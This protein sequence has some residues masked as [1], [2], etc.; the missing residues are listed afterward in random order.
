MPTRL[1]A[2]KLALLPQGAQT[3]GGITVGELVEYG[4]FPHRTR[5]SGLTEADRGIVRW[6]LD[7][8]ATTALKDREMD[9]L[10][11]GQRQRAWIAMALAQKTGILFLDEPHTYLDISHQWSF[12]ICS[13]GSIWSRG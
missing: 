13:A 9:Q 3:P 7:C 12:C 8:T 4:R 2:Q 6:A 1:V 10:S 5:L 11:G